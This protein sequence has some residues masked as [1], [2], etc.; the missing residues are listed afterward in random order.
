MFYLRRLFSNSDETVGVFS[1]NE[2]KLCWIIEDEFRTIKVYGE[3]RI[4][5]ETYELTLM[6]SG[7]H[8][9]RYLKKYGKEFHKGMIELKDVTGFKG[10]L[11]H[12]GNDEGDTAGCLLPNKAAVV[13]KDN[14]Y[15]GLSSAIAYEYIYPMI[16]NPLYA[17]EQVLL[18]ITDE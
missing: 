15:T 18:K 16:A 12:I 9:E 5:A 6:T 1:F 14:R 3:T 2:T 11:I 7:D 10:I 13:E 17:G 8:H 4:P